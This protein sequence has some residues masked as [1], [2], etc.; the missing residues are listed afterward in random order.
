MQGSA[1]YE[2]E[3]GI[4]EVMDDMVNGEWVQRRIRVSITLRKMR[5]SAW[6]V[7]PEE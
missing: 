7:G 4:K 3:H 6:Q 2:W 5:K 1:R